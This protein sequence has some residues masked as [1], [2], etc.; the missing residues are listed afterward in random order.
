M[1]PKFQSPPHCNLLRHSYLS[2][3][4]YP[5]PSHIGLFLLLR[6]CSA[7]VF[8]VWMRLMTAQ[9]VLKGFTGQPLVEFMFVHGNV[10]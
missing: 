8:L 7:A 9:V 5:F 4:T 1:P 2:P 3:I 6:C 10:R